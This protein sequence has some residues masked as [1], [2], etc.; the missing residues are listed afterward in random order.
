MC[1]PSV[2]KSNW[3]VANVLSSGAKML[4]VNILIG[5][6]AAATT[7]GLVNANAMSLLTNG[8]FENGVYSSTIGGWTN[9]A[10]IGWTSSAGWDYLNGI[11]NRVTT[12]NPYSGSHAIFIGNNPGDPLA[13][14][15]QTF[16]DVVGT[17]YNVSFHLQ[18]SASGGNFQ[19]L[20]NGI[21]GVNVTD[22]PISNYKLESF[23]FTGTGSDILSFTAYSGFSSAF[24]DGVNVSA[25]PLPA[26]LPLLATGVGVMGLFCWCRNRKDKRTNVA[27]LAAA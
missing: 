13:T 19:A 26:T 6:L 11:F 21:P 14:L 9:N 1:H 5:A 12:S 27:A 4:R 15:S 25:V 7:F 18:W 24:V 3:P 8:D 2:A 10:P 17:T 16:S 23:A 22:T 20:L